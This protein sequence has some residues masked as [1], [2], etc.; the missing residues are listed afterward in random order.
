[1]ETT[2]NNSGISAAGGSYVVGNAVASGARSRAEVHDS[3]LTS[4][5][6]SGANPLSPQEIADL[7]GKL[8][9]EFG[10][11]DHPERADL[12]ECA[13]D[14]QEEVVAE[15]PRRGKLRMMTR[16]IAESVAD[17]VSLAPLAL[18]IQEAVGEL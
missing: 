16:N 5:P 8:I 14:A 3:G 11:S 13:Q 1:M 4:T 7:L 17:F 12:A 10:R 15:E 9:D 2:G 18:A 6:G